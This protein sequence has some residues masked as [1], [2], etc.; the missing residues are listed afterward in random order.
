MKAMIL[1][2]GF[3]TRLLPYTRHTPKP[4]F[5][6]S[7]QP[8]L[9]GIIRSLQDAGCESVI[10]NTHYL[11]NK[12]DSF[13]AS[14][15]YDIPVQ[16]RYEPVPLG[17]GGAI[18]NVSDFWDNR[19]FIVI[20]S[21]I[22]TNLDMKDI[23]SF[24]VKQDNIATLVLHDY[25]KYNHVSVDRDGYIIN[26][27][28]H[29]KAKNCC[30]T[31]QLAFTGIQVLNP[32]ILDFIPAGKFLSII[33]AYRKL[34]QKGNKVKAFISKHF[35]WKDIG[36]IESYKETAAEKMAEKAFSNI[37]PDYPGKSIRS[38]RLK[39][40]GSDRKWYRF[41][42]GKKSIVMVDHGIRTDSA[43]AEVD[44]FV[45]IGRHLYNKGIKIPKIYSYDTFSGMVF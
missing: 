30:W 21:D 33:D 37:R 27:H 23:Y 6:I 43:I 28:D 40:D 12:I 38:V 45:S 20:N 4:L 1:A 16:T 31:K 44:S 32:L 26:F 35:Y 19:S 7:G 39:G 11:Y 10:I 41:Y 8:V 17:T 14:V 25:S 13:L 9:D 3:G 22:V 42:S 2:A 18:K 34:I 24:H 29:K 15:K 36:T 5:T